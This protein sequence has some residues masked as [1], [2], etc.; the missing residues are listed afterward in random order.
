MLRLLSFMTMIFGIQGTLLGMGLSLVQPP[1]AKVKVFPLPSD[2]ASRAL[3]QSQ[4]GKV[5]ESI[6]R[7]IASSFTDFTTPFKEIDREPK[8]RSPKIMNPYKL[9]AAVEWNGENLAIDWKTQNYTGSDLDN[10]LEAYTKIINDTVFAYCNEFCD[11]ASYFKSSSGSTFTVTIFPI[12]YLLDSAYDENALIWHVDPLTD[13]Q[14]LLF[15]DRDEGVQG[16]EL[17]IRP[18]NPPY[19]PMLKSKPEYQAELNP[20]DWVMFKGPNSEHQVTNMVSKDNNLTRKTI[21]I[22]FSK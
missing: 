10:V 12:I 18:K 16:G 8:M 4:F 5:N 1:V 15:V 2:E 13:F 9:T 21:A 11:A 3:I 22:F 14:A 17:Q 19:W 6:F 20:G 7:T